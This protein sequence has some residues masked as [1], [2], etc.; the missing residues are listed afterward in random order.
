MQRHKGMTPSAAPSIIANLG[1]ASLGRIVSLSIGLGITALLA[2]TLRPELF[3]IYTTIFAY[4]V[5]WQ[6]AADFGLYLT[7]T[8]EVAKHPTQEARHLAESLLVRAGLLGLAFVCSVLLARALPSLR[9]HL[10]AVAAGALGL[11]FQSFSQLFMGIYQHHR[12]VW[13]A[14]LGDLFGRL[15]QGA[16]IG[17]AIALHASV[18]AMVVAF[19]GGTVGA[20]AIHRLLLPLGQPIPYRRALQSIRP[21]TVRLLAV[22]WPLAA[23]LMLN[24][25]YFRIDTVILSLVRPP[26]EV[27][28]YGLAYRIIESALFF[29]AMFGGL[30]L[31]QM[32]ATVR[33]NRPHARRLLRQSTQVLLVAAGYTVMVLWLLNDSIVRLVAGI[34]YQDAAPLLR[35]LSLALAIMFLGNLFGYSL[36]ALEKQK[37]LLGLYCALAA[38]NVGLNVLLVPRWGAIAAAWTTVVTEGIAMLCAAAIVHRALSFPLPF[39]T[40]AKVSLATVATILVLWQAVPLWPS[41]LTGI[42]ATI[43]YG[44]LCTL[45]TAVRW[46]DL[47]TLVSSAPPRPAVSTSLAP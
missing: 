16:S 46:Q 2:R 41:L 8:R 38:L 24:V 19:A 43:M 35:I 3:G 5:L 44:A 26:A 32:S 11:S 18:T 23:L 22:S 13:R 9:P 6:T 21:A 4:C 27:G 25:I 39:S 20:F 15:V 45:F 17:G 36:V 47:S 29:P 28:Q 14:T 12:L 30:L 33:Q 31:P 1:I 37:M 10:V 40:L 34:Q 7:L 42:L